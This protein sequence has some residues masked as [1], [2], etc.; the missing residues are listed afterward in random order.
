MP[1]GKVGHHPGWKPLQGSAAA[2]SQARLHARAGSPDPSEGTDRDEENTQ[3]TGAV[4]VA[5]VLPTNGPPSASFIP[6]GRGWADVSRRSRPP[7]SEDGAPTLRLR[8][9]PWIARENCGSFGEG[10][11]EGEQAR[12]QRRRTCQQ[13]KRP[14]QLAEGDPCHLGFLHTTRLRD[15]LR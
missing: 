5:L 2:M 13:R 14:C 3:P 7:V 11:R 12:R 4:E 9:H 8:C 10:G 1:S 15:T 6:P